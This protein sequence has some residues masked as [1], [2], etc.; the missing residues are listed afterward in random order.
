M[1]GS[2]F[3]RGQYCDL[4]KKLLIHF[5]KIIDTLLKF[6]TVASEHNKNSS[7]GLIGL[8]TIFFFCQAFPDSAIS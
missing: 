3:G 7:N 1:S 8:P 4:R 6:G 2:Y 5:G